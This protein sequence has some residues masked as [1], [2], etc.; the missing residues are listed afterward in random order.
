MSQHTTSLK[1]SSTA[2]QDFNSLAAGSSQW[3]SVFL[4]LLQD[5]AQALTALAGVYPPSL[6][7]SIP[8]LSHSLHTFP[9]S[10]PPYLPSLTP[11]IFPL[12]LPP[13]LPSLTPS[14]SSLSH[15]LHT[16]PLSL[17]PYLPSLTPSISSL[18]HS[19]HIFPLSFPPYL[20]CLPRRRDCGAV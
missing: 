14:I 10:F 1:P 11:S 20:P 2:E 17:P 5:A 3:C 18:S 7:P 13:Y 6:T 16:L 8:S 15:S 9:L 4:L 12:S 19:L